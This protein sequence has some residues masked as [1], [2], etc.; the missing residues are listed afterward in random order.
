RAAG[1]AHVGAFLEGKTTKALGFIKS[2]VLRL[3]IIIDLSLRL[4]RTG[5]VKYHPKPIDVNQVV[6]NALGAGYAT[7]REPSAVDDPREFHR[8]YDLDCMSY[9]Q[10]RRPREIRRS[11]TQSWA[12]LVD[13]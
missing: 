2:A 12:V 8:C 7:V 5:R 6:A 4:S 3:R 10:T 13:R 11:I 1:R 9:P